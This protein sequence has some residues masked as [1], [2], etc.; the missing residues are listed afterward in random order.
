MRMCNK[1][2]FK[3]WHIILSVNIKCSVYVLI[4]MLLTCPLGRVRG[5]SPENK[6]N[7][8][9][10]ITV[11]AAGNNINLMWDA[12]TVDINGNPEEGA[13]HY[14]V[15]CDT[16][17]HFTHTL[18]NWVATVSD[19][20]QFEH[21]SSWIGLPERNLYYT[22]T[23]VDEYGNESRPSSQVGEFDFALLPGESGT[24]FRYNALTAV[25]DNPV[26]VDAQ[27]LAE[28]IGG[29]YAAY[30]WDKENQT[31]KYWLPDFAL[32]ENFELLTGRPYFLSLTDQAISIS[33]QTGNLPIP[34]SVV[35]DLIPGEE[36]FSF[37]YNLISLP[38]E[39]NDIGTADELAQHIG[40]VYSIYTW[41]NV[42][43]TWSFWIPEFALGENF[44]V[45]PGYPYLLSL[46]HNAPTVWPNPSL[47]KQSAAGELNHFT[48]SA[49]AVRLHPPRP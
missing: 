5:G 28:S 47:A 17:A 30:C 29:V 48:R 14:R 46:T 15:Y 9:G 3:I 36:E 43:Q 22:V 27:S 13:I 44:K 6:G 40:G 34:G 42:E 18:S 39:M 35:F 24:E 26:I 49:A 32:G 11:L 20:T 19:I 25:L 31:W 23:A 10:Y 21:S 37:S 4:L 41:D 38:L 7:D 8:S 12:V 45:R 33:T 16:L 1:N 2:V